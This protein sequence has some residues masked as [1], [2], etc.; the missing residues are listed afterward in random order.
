MSGFVSTPEHRQLVRKQFAEWKAGQRSFSQL[1]YM[2]GMQMMLA[3]GVAHGRL[4]LNEQELVAWG[5]EH[6][7]PFKEV[8]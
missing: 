5:R 7:D 4:S 1:P 2:L 6:F 3:F 8:A